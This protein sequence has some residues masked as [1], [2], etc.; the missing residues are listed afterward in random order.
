MD[1]GIWA[2][3][4]DLREADR[5]EYLAWFHDV[6]MPEKVAR[7]G[8][9]W[10]AHYELER[11]G[12]LAL[13]G[14]TLARVF[15]D[16]SPGQLAQRQGAETRRR[17]GLRRQAHACI[18]VEEHRVEGPDAAARGAGPAPG[19]VIQFGNYNAPD[20]AGEDDLG[21]WYAQERL[22]ALAKLPGC[23]GARKMLATVGA[24][25]HAILHEFASIEA[26][27]RH[28]GPLEAQGRDPSTWM[29]RIRPR[30]QHA[31]WSPAVGRR[32]AERAKDGG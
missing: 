2:I 3:A 16:P 19:P 6:H 29:G 20:A 27:E 23:V 8:Y 21:A 18:L 22:P 17:I 7:P 26:R 15:L 4:Y 1:R 11:G 30:L 10:A 32:V 31:P 9:L 5:A 28:F 25:K 24:Y 14:A 13:F 12:Y